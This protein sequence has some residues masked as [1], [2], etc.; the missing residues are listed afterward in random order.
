MKHTTCCE[1]LDATDMK[2]Q[3]KNGGALTALLSTAR[4]C[5]KGNAFCKHLSYLWVC[6]CVWYGL[7]TGAS[8]RFY[9]Q[10]DETTCNIWA[11]GAPLQTQPYLTPNIPR[12]QSR[13]R[14][15]PTKSDKTSHRFT[16]SHR[17]QQERAGRASWEQ[18]IKVHVCVYEKCSMSTD[19]TAENNTLT[20]RWRKSSARS[21]SSARLIGLEVNGVALNTNGHDASLFTDLNITVETR[22]KHPSLKLLFGGIYFT[23]I[24]R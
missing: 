3:P 19:P 11:S 15:A 21:F 2:P 8:L 22:T 24:L 18:S 17:I 5:R 16:A 4:H 14:V 23:L 1:N 10:H 9:L 13:T 12:G 6:V 20:W 7:V